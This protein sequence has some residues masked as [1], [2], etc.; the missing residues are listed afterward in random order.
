MLSYTITAAKDT[1]CYVRRHGQ[2]QME[3]N[4]I[5]FAGKLADC[6]AYIEKCFQANDPRVG[7]S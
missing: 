5:L 4:E 6:L 3:V 7:G 1:G 2:S